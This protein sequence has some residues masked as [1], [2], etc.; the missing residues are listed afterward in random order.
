[1]VFPK[2]I[3]YISRVVTFVVLTVLTQIG[4]MVYLLNFSTYR[5]I[6]GKVSDQWLRR[7]CRLAT[8]ILFYLLATVLI[9]PV[10]AK[11]FGRVQLPSGKGSNLRPLTGLTYLLNRNYVRKDLRDA[12]VSIAGEMN[13]KYP[14]TVVK[15]LD[16]NFPFVNGF[17]LFPHLSHNDGKKLDL[18]FCYK[19]RQSLQE[20]NE[21]PSP[22]GYGI[23]EEPVGAEKN[24]AQFCDQKGYWQYSFLKSILPQHRKNDFVFYPQKTKYLVELFASDA[25]IGKIFIEP[26]LQSRLQ[27]TSNK[28]RFHGCQAVRHDDHIHVQL[29]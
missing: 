29:K 6:N 22:I 25:R 7:L 1:M 20:T 15:Y 24:T 17:P 28:I 26:H 10:L 14:G 2:I 21:A 8:F 23:C 3:T 4:G 16:A 19:S 5:F 11:P 13:R 18:S 27:L 12:A 9:V